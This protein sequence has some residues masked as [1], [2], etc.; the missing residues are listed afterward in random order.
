MACIIRNMTLPEMEIAIYLAYKEGWNPGTTDGLAFYEA[1]PKGFFIA[2]IDSEVVG[3]ISAVKYSDDYGFIGF[4]VVDGSHRGSSA[5]TQLALVALKY[6]EGCNIG[7]DGVLSRV[8]NYERLNF[9][10]AYKN[11]RFETVGSK[12][13]ID[14]RIF[15]LATVSP[16][17]IYEYDL[18]CFPAPR[19]S[20]LKAWF[21]MPETYSLAYVEDGN[22]YGYGAIRKCR[23]GYKIGP[24]FADKR[25]IAESLYKALATKAVDELIYLDIPTINTEALEIATKYDMKMVF[26]T[27]RMYSSHTPDIRIDKIFGIT[28]FELG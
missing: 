28:S 22:I 11:A 27:A 5:G 3:C 25:E 17:L 26:E 1:D 15:P 7:I 4:Y 8:N 24:L 19:K 13:N 16:E 14:K 10:F 21:S 2:E 23:T 20:F 12:Y 9:K 6:L 18:Q